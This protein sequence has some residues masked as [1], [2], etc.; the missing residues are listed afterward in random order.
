M[1]IETPLVL[2]A[3]LRKEKTKELPLN[4]GFKMKTKGKLIQDVKYI[5]VTSLYCKL[6]HMYTFIHFEGP[7][8]TRL[9]PTAHL[10]KTLS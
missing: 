8:A 5:F 6:L 3:A 4:K 9:G 2:L 10:T 1:K 7:R